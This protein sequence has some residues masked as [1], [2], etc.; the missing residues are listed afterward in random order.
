MSRLNIKID[1]MRNELS[2]K[3]H[4]QLMKSINTK[5]YEHLLISL[6]AKVNQELWNHVYVCAIEQFILN[7][8]N[9]ND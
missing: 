8:E 5:V 9:N 6:N 2:S 4:Y 7:K 3:V 1:I